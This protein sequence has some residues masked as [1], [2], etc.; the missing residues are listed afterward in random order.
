MVKEQRMN[1]RQMMEESGTGLKDT[2]YNKITHQ[3]L[4]GYSFKLM[5]Y[6]LQGIP[7]LLNC[8]TG[9]VLIMFKNNEQ[10]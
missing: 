8:Y 10:K 2:D 3:S 6:G 1:D 7:V 9:W 5:S 4:S